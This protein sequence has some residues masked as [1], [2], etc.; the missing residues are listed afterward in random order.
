MK[1]TITMRQKDYEHLTSQ[2]FS[3]KS[4]E[5]VAYLYCRSSITDDET[6]LLVR[7]VEF[8][9]PSEIITA[10]S[11]GVSIASTSVARA[12]KHAR[13][14]KQGLIF[15]HSHP[16]G[17]SQY[18]EQDNKEEAKLFKLAYQQVDNAVH[19]SI[20]IPC[21]SAPHGRVWFGDG[22]STPISLIRVVGKR[23]IHYYNE[24]LFQNETVSHIFDRQIRAFGPEIQQTLSRLNI[25]IV[26][27]G[28]T[29]S[30]IFEQLTRLGVKNI[31]IADNDV[32]EE[33]NVNRVYGSHLVDKGQK[34]VNI[35]KR[36]AHLIGLGTDIITFDKPITYESVLQQFRNCDII[37]GC[38]DDEWGK[39]LLS[40]V[41]VY[42]GIPVFDMGVKIDSKE[43]I[44]KSIQGR[45]TTLLPEEACLF[46][47]GR[48]NTDK[49]RAESEEE[50]N[51][52][53]AS[54]LRKEGY[55]PELPHK[56]PAVISFTTSI[57]S[58]AI[59]EF[60]HRLTGC[61]GEERESSEVTY[62]FDQT[63]LGTN[64]TPSKRDCFCASTNHVYRGDTY[65]FLGVNWREE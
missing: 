30:S 52:K 12:I 58:V 9:N 53:N 27:V 56:A 38:T 11:S 8:A 21:A 60:L 49:I 22:T 4:I 16:E 10:S 18:S 55:I 24:H 31:T 34:K 62:L 39:S 13:L 36:L 6:R 44:I 3:D 33:T 20:V 46:C 42:Y 2:L 5:G 23:F 40:R 61:F 57:A 17:V 28:G 43:G 15:V 65:P 50:T 41:A 14:T 25:G 35:S 63:R 64:R 29:G 48:L 51:P 1:Y 7:E 45:V 59:S 47:R 26:G 32:F 54:L 19:A 37:F